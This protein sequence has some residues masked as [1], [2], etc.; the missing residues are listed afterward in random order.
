MDYTAVRRTGAQT[1]TYSTR[2]GMEILLVVPYVHGNVVGTRINVHNFPP[3][4]L[5]G[6]NPVFFPAEKSIIFLCG[7]ISYFSV[8][9]NRGFFVSRPV[10]DSG[11]DNGTARDAGQ[12]TDGLS[13]MGQ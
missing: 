7:K 12:W 8:W 5:F 3:V 10:L 1:L 4:F 2:S 9:K 6:K 11:R 13:S